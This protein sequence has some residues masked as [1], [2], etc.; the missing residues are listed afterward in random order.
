M[1]SA[2][3]NNSGRRTER[4][5]GHHHR[6]VLGQP[7]PE[8]RGAGKGK[9]G[10]QDEPFRRNIGAEPCER[11]EPDDHGRAGKA[12]TAPASL[13]RVAGSCRVIPR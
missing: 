1:I 7:Q 10:E 12:S 13:R 6:I 8:D 2:A 4:S 11:I 9:G 5:G 3:G